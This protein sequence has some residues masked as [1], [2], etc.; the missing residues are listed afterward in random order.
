MRCVPLRHYAKLL[1]AV[2]KLYLTGEASFNWKRLTNINRSGNFT[3][4]QW[5]LCRFLIMGVQI[6][7]ILIWNQNKCNTFY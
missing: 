2:R 5:N 4:F 7:F 6:A 3:K 1:K